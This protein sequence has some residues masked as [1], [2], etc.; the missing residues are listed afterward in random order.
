MNKIILAFEFSEKSNSSLEFALSIAEKTNNVLEIV[1]VDNILDDLVEIEKETIRQ[2][3]DEILRSVV[4]QNYDRLPGGYLT[5]SIIIGDVCEALC[6]KVSFENAD[7]IIIGTHSENKKLDT[8]WQH[9]TA[10]KVAEKS[11]CA[12]MTVPVDCEYNELRN[13]VFP[14]DFDVSTLEKTVIVTYL[15]QRFKSHIYI[16]ALQTSSEKTHIEKIKEYVNEVKTSFIDNQI[17]C[18]LEYRNTNNLAKEIMSFSHE[19][20]VDLVAVMLHQ[21][22]AVSNLIFGT[23]THQL[24][25]ESKV[26]L[27]I[28]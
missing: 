9:S 15:A 7:L 3:Y 25:L 17:S 28:V 24:I 18:E 10:S 23:Y 13:I 1:W 6:E 27:L 21:E 20:K 4:S 26:P 5:Y 19:R 2:R 8:R 16:L 22:T 12:V 14:I 11:K